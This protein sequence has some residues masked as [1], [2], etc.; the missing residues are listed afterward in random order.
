M[1]FITIIQLENGI[2]DSL[3]IS[4]MNKIEYVKMRSGI[5]RKIMVAEGLRILPSN[6]VQ[7]S[8]K[9]YRRKKLSKRELTRYLEE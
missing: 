7:K 3:L 9:D 8:K 5:R 1:L 2:P 6:Q 4:G